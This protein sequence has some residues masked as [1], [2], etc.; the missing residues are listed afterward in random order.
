MKFRKDFVTN[1]SSSSFIVAVNENKIDGVVK[2]LLD[3]ILNS[4]GNETSEAQLFQIDEEELSYYDED[5]VEMVHKM[6]EEGWKIYQK[7]VSY[8]DE[9][10]YDIMKEAFSFNRNYVRCLNED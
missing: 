9:A 4:R 8:D 5:F 10:L 1:S 3:I 6:N 2:N 7:S